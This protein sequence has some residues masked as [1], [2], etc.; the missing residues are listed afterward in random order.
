MLRIVLM[1]SMIV[2]RIVGNWK[3][4]SFEMIYLKILS[5]KSKSFFN[6]N[7]LVDLE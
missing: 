4:E 7:M 2:L 6:V 1:N 3:H 5:K